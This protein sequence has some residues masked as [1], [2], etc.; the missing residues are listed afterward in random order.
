MK[1]KTMNLLKEI[2]KHEWEISSALHQGQN[3]QVFKIDT[4][5]RRDIYRHTNWSHEY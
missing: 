1:L 3:I 4:L 5:G 2:P